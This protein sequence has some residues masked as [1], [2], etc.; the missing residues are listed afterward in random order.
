MTRSDSRR[1]V[2]LRL[3][4]AL[5]A[6]LVAT[7]LAS[8]MLIAAWDDH[9]L[10]YHLVHGFGRTMGWGITG[11]V[12][13]AALFTVTLVVAFA[14]DDDKHVQ[15]V[16]LLAAV[17]FVFVPTLV[18]LGRWRIDFLSHPVP[19]VVGVALGVVVVGVG[20]SPPLLGD[21][22]TAFP[23]A[24]RALYA[25]VAG[26]AIV[27]FVER[28]LTYESPI[29]VVEN[30]PTIDQVAGGP[31][32]PLVDL[33]SV[34][35]LVYLLGYFTRYSDVTD[36]VISSPDEETVARFLGGL[37]DTADRNRRYEATSLEGG[38]VL[39][40]A[41]SQEASLPRISGRVAFEFRPGNGSFARRREVSYDNIRPVTAADAD[42]MSEVADRRSSLGSRLWFAFR[43]HLLLAAPGSVQSLL[44]RS[45]GAHLDRLVRADV[46]LLLAPMSDVLRE[47]LI[48]E[49]ADFDESWV[50][51][52]DYTGRDG[53]REDDG[54][55]VY[56][57]I[58]SACTGA[59]MPEVYVVAT[60]GE[61]ALALHSAESFD[62]GQ[63]LQFLRTELL[64][65]GSDCRGRVLPVSDEKDGE[66]YEDVLQSL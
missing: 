38:D 5:V 49:G 22:R 6:I 8:R 4:G 11:V 7:A 13:F 58:V 65:L 56:D 26:I 63:F 3:A 2:A 35:G 31:L 41:R 55:G 60:D 27:G 33:V 17:V 42:A 57:G 23:N 43:R 50:R 44:R 32:T 21:G 28:Y 9:G 14:L 66:G 36:V 47:S 37:Y 10:V 29:V 19:A 15:G 61:L 46:I 45:G 59:S 64:R 24:A 1:A 12:V 39:N 48:E 18:V 16:L 40:A 54:G 51:N 30:T 34:F 25:V 52:R 20:A 62:D 53:S